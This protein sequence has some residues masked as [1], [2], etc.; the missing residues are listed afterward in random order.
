MK[1]MALGVLAL[2]TLTGCEPAIIASA[3]RSSDRENFYM[4]TRCAELDMRD[5]AAMQQ[6]FPRYV[7][8]SGRIP[9]GQLEGQGYHSGVLVHR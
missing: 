8:R 1:K 2:A 9:A 5:N 4:E 3:L 6:L 7:L